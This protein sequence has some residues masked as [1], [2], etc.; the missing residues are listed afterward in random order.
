MTEVE[1]LPNF[2]LKATGD[3]NLMGMARLGVVYD[4]IDKCVNYVSI[5]QNCVT[6]MRMQVSI[7]ALLKE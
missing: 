1:P 4:L 7:F 5:F 3:I 6:S 2:N